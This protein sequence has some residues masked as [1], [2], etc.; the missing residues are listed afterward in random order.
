[1][2]DNMTAVFGFGAIFALALVMFARERRAV[3]KRKAAR[4]GREVDLNSIFDPARE[5]GQ[6]T[7]D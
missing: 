1:M 7:K 5:T 4:G 3:A 2:S 6:P